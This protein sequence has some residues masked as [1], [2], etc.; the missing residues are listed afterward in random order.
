MPFLYWDIET[1]SA[2]DLP[3]VHAWRYSGHASTDIWLLAF[4]VNDGEIKIWKPGEPIPEEF[5]IAVRDL[6][7]TLIAHNAAFEN[8][9]AERILA[10]RYH[11][12]L[13]PI[14]RIRCTQA[15][16]LASALPP[17]LDDTAAALK[18]DIR[19]DEE[20]RQLMLLMARPRQRRPGE[21]RNQWHWHDADP[22]HLEQLGRYCARD[23]EV[24][25]EIHKR[26]PPLSD[27]E[28]AT[29]ILDQGINHRGFQV[30]VALAEAGEKIVA[31]RL[32]QINQEAAEVT[33]G[34]VE[35]ISQV[36]RIEAFVAARGA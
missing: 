1:R 31:A 3:K 36:A 23:V 6:D 13:C 26:V 33:G 35:K 28:Q 10:P 20:G 34:A 19:K 27:A 4:A 24:E 2:L 16:S 9:I 7:W 21:D 30:D 8:A 18:L 5:H 12:P 15:A 14:E 29:W 11:W 25:R 22:A 32:E 17:S